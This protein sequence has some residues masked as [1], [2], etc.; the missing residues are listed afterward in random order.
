[1]RID[2][3][4]MRERANPVIT[5]RELATRIGKTQSQVSRL[6]ENPDKI[7]IDVLIQI[8]TA[9]GEDISKI[10]SEANSSTPV[11]IDPGDPYKLLFSEIDFL[12][13]YFQKGPAALYSVKKGLVEALRGITSEYH[14]KPRLMLVGS[15]DSGKSTLAN[16]LLGSRYL[17]TS[18]QPA[19]KVV[20]YIKHLSEKPEWLR[21]DVLILGEDFNP[22]EQ[23]DEKNCMDNKI[24]AGNLKTLDEY[25]THNGLR[26]TDEAAFALVFLESPILNACEI[27]DLP[28]FENSTTDNRKATSHLA[29]GD[30]IV[31]ACPYISFMAAGD[32]IRLT[33]QLRAMPHLCSAD[34]QIDP[35]MNLF[36]VATHASVSVS[37]DDITS[38]TN[39]A[40]KRI[41]RQLSE[42]SIPIRNGEPQKITSDLIKS[43]I[44]PFFYENA[45]R[46]ITLEKALTHTLKLEIPEFR[47]GMSST[48][49]T[50]F[51]RT[52]KA[53]LDSELNQMQKALEDNRNA[54]TKAAGIA[55]KTKVLLDKAKNMRKTI[56]SR[57]N[58]K[59]YPES[60]QAAEGILAEICDRKYIEVL[61][62]KAGFNEKS[63]ATKFAPAYVWE[64]MYGKLSS[65]LADISKSFSNEEITPFIEAYTQAASSVDSTI[66]G[67]GVQMQVGAF[68]ARGAFLG[69]LAGL[70]VVGALAVWA[71]GLGNLGAYIIAA[72]LGSLLAAI[73]ISVSGGTATITAAM[74]ALGGP[75]GIAVGIVFVAALIGLSLFKSWERR[76]A[77]RIVKILKKKETTQQMMD[78]ISTYWQDTA[79]AFEK[80][81]DSLESSWQEYV[82]NLTNLLRKKEELIR[83]IED[84]TA[85]RDFIAGLP[86]QENTILLAAKDED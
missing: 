58:S 53:R 35:L 9:L 70:G 40:S 21:E 25:G 54:Q 44:F 30:I 33:E 27:I 50:L 6:E 12:E 81:A 20:T 32:I 64:H 65:R 29:V 68:N 51:K 76:L 49:I 67:V 38:I 57:I 4:S 41:Q 79:S 39:L 73:G 7:P 45:E 80:G 63:E 84:I 13:K 71:A 5:Q 61:F 83:S 26:K 17:P 14:R 18:F 85:V 2:V 69:G 8:C 16:A 56:L 48:A 15:F 37:D 24:V 3:R 59:Y 55:K 72:K 47:K 28:G 74:A 42:F 60:I 82:R 31:Y 62:K 10:L 77:E 11:G 19:T 36:I 1:M 75:A 22:L 23:D 66:T 78:G 46:R 52:N 43:R 86:W 34:S